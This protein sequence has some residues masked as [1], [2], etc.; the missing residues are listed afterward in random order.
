MSGERWRNLD[1]LD[2]ETRPCHPMTLQVFL[3]D[4]QYRRLQRHALLPPATI[5]GSQPLCRGA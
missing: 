1:H 3:V 4:R 5:E 2:S